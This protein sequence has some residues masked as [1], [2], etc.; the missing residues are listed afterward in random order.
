MEKVK[1][2]FLLFSEAVLK[3]RLVRVSS[4]ERLSTLNA[5]ASICIYTRL[6]TAASAWQRQCCKLPVSA[7]R[8]HAECSYASIGSASASIRHCGV[9]YSSAQA[10]PGRCISCQVRS[11][12]I[13]EC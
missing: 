7:G 13:L 6:S 1:V 4:I 10:E 8:A 11:L 3:E 12:S 2:T 5:H 9:P